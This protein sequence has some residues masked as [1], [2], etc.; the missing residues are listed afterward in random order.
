MSEGQ[1]VLFAGD[2]ADTL[3]LQEPQ[4]PRCGPQL[5]QL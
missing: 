4:L 2:R 5:A 3:P 1:Q